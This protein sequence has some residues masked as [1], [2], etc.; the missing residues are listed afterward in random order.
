MLTVLTYFL[1]SFFGY[2]RKAGA[3][4]KRHRFTFMR[5][6]F[7][8]DWETHTH[9]KKKNNE[10]SDRVNSEVLVS[11]VYAWWQK[12]KREKKRDEEKNKRDVKKTQEKDVLL[13]S[14]A[15]PFFLNSLLHIRR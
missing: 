14:N 6:Q 2:E 3:K 10:R 7:K 11:S 8:N 12:K 4:D 1:S 15:A 9:S 5:S 13:T